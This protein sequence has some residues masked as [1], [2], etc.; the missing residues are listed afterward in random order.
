MWAYLSSHLDHGLAK[1]FQYEPPV[2]SDTE[3]HHCK[4]K[5]NARAD[6]WRAGLPLSQQSRALEHTQITR[7]FLGVFDQEC[8]PRL[9]ELVQKGLSCRLK[10]FLLGG[11]LQALAPTEKNVAS[12]V[13]TLLEHAKINDHFLFF[14]NSNVKT[15]SALIQSWLA[16]PTRLCFLWW[17]WTAPFVSERFSFLPFC[18]RW[19]DRL[20]VERIGQQHSESSDMRVMVLCW[21]PTDAR[22]VSPNFD[23]GR[24][25]VDVLKAH[26]CRCSV[27]AMLENLHRMCKKYGV[28]PVILSNSAFPPSKTFWGFG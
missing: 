17:V 8:D 16:I 26:R 23:F 5:M 9:S 27:S 24:H 28:E 22:P 21:R 12:E 6:L 11:D 1:V 20:K 10:R 2:H 13:E 3:C 14:W 4:R 19:T 15:S 18:Y 25:V 7:F